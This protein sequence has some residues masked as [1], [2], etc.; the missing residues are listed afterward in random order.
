VVRL[1]DKF[2]AMGMTSLIGKPALRKEDPILLN[3]RGRFVDDVPTPAGTLHLVFVLSSRAHARVLSIGAEKARKAEGVVAVYT[4]HDFEARIRS[5]L[6]DIEQPGFQPVARPV[7]AVDRV[8]FVG[9]MVAVVVAKD[10]YSAED[11]AN[12]VQVEYEDLP[13]LATMEAALAANAIR[14]H[15]NTRNNVLFRAVHKTEGFD[16][17]FAAAQVVVQDTFH[18]PR[19]AGL[20][21]EPRG[22]LAIYDS[23]LDTLTFYTSTQIP[24]IVRTG[25][26]E[27]L[28]LDETRLRVL[29]PEVGGGFGTKAYLYPE[30][31]VA[32]FLAR[33]LKK[34]IKWICDRREDMLSSVQGRGYEFHVAL[35]FAADGQLIGAKANL[36]CD[37]GAYPGYPFGAATSAG[38][39]AIYLPGPYRMQH[40]SYETRAVTTN[41]CPSG[42][43]RGVAAPSAFFATEVLMDRAAKELGL[44]P[45]E[46]RRRNVL[47][48]GD[49]PYAS[50]VGVPFT[51][52]TFEECLRR[53]LEESGYDR[54]RHNLPADRMVDG[55]LRGI[56]IG[57]IV[58][59]TGQ[60]ASRYR[61]RGIRRVPGFDSARVQLA[62]NGRALIYVS[63]ASQGQGHLTSFAQVAA[64]QLGL[65][66]DDVSVIE[67]DT[68]QG[69]YGTGTFASR[70]AVLGGGAVMRAATVVRQ[71]IL[72]I[73]ASII[74]ADVDD[75]QISASRVH[76]AGI[77]GSGVPVREIATMAYGMHDRALPPGEGFGLEATEYYDPPLS[78]IANAT[79][80]AQVAI[81][82]LTGFIELE[83]YVVAHDCGRLINPLIVEGQIHGATVQGIGGV[84][85]EALHYGEEGQ[86]TTT[87]LLDYLIPTATDV[88][89]MAVHHEES[90][91]PDTEGGFKG[92]GEGGVI[93]ALPALAN[94]IA[95]ALSAYHAKITRLPVR[96]QD[97]IRMLTGTPNLTSS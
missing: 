84:L 83:R 48:G 58:E 10:R 34:P 67:G 94:A 42:V 59:H 25:L 61:L 6:P 63:Q 52:G 9:E 66:L 50:A 19:I 82:P 70:G 75:L 31:L 2:G 1:R 80:I 47:R 33:T 78:T 37:L 28:N 30:E 7:M 87:S 3:G 60:G 62:P 29:A 88:P 13:V 24:H 14:L 51:S 71:K 22:C 45:A 69:P 57:C 74:E 81:D 39:A 76:L 46:I 16:A 35:A 36:L 56:G 68:A 12:L 85:S 8:R 40:Y 32:A 5:L 97:V 95:D 54:F 86:L 73:A 23:A 96:P 27:A 4:G 15:P 92:V 26:A 44:D 89:K 72:R 64:E 17:A 79:H 90:R 43:F 20:C 18:S 11:G 55:K 65:E 21:I 53:S 38:G 49:L 77:P 93:G 41:T 91:S